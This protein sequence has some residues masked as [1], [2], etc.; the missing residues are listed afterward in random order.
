[1]FKFLKKIKKQANILGPGFITGAADD[2]PSGIATYSI[3]GAQFG[4]KLSFLSW[5]L[6]PMMIAVQEA[7][8]RVGLITGKG[9]VGVIKTYYPK[10][11]L[12]I[13]VLL[14]LIAN[15]INIGAD[16]GIMAQSAKMVFGFTFGFWLIIISAITI[17]AE[18]FIPYRIYAKFLRVTSMFLLVYVLTSFLVI[19]DW[20]MV[21]R[22]TITPYLSLEKDF[23]LTIVGFLGTTISP[24][25][26]FWQASQEIEEKIDK[27]LTSD[28]GQKKPTLSGR[29][30]RAMR[31]DT[32]IGM[33]FSNLITFFIIATTAV[34]LN[35]NGIFDIKTPN[36]AAL[37][38][39]P[40]AGDLAF[41]LFAI[42]IIGIGLQSIPVLAGSIAYAV[43]ETFGLEEGLFK[44]FNQAKLFYLTIAFSI[45]V[46]VFINVFNI[47]TIQ[48]LFY[49]AII[50]GVISVPLIFII[51]KIAN[52]KK[53]VGQNTSPPK[54]KFFGW[55]AFV[56]MLM[57]VTLM[58]ASLLKII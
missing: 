29:E 49:S 30:V 27:G 20:A 8:A 7:S 43:A 51:M 42:G 11:L 1:M 5:L 56:F 24:Y 44:N 46:G 6:I 2:D 33:I 39:K 41:I 18:I 35:Q 50:N 37:A 57:T 25:L 15:I 21:L 4:Y 9:L 3:A 45:I 32:N 22:H 36:E 58:I 23:L 16:L 55:L 52:D 53:I 12:I 13:T 40:I 17:M 10:T 38:L 14:L 19:K 54:L 26:F 34:T 28:F 48:A 31:Q 47:N